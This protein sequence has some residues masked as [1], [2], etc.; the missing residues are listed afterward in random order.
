MENE[1]TKYPSRNCTKISVKSYTFLVYNRLSIFNTTRSVNARFAHRSE[2]QYRIS[3][4][5]I[6][7]KLANSCR[8]CTRIVIELEIIH[9]EIF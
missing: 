5:V 4:M 3:I 1:T 9:E 7:S 2:G 8:I 6:R